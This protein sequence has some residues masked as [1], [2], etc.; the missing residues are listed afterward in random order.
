MI[1]LLLLGIQ[2]EKDT[3]FKGKN[4]VVPIEKMVKQYYKKRGYGPNGGPAAGEIGLPENRLAGEV[5]VKP[6][7]LIFKR[8]Y[9]SV[10]M[11]VLGWFIPMACRK[12][13]VRDEIR[14]FPEDF[15]C[16]LGIWPRG[17]S[18][19]FRK[20][21]DRL[22]KISNSSREVDLGVY[23]KSVEAAWLMFSFQESTCMSEANNRLMAM[24]ELPH[25]CTF[26]RMMDKVEIL[27][28]PKFI[29]KRAVKKW[30]KVK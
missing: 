16:R 1:F 3:L 14:A 4:T 28:L 23:L 18:V 17:A 6:S 30:E 11:A 24:G 8:I 22:K 27:L 12:E 19:T 13:G 29:A 10:I 7:G 2:K 25:T 5:V 21:G 26:I 15:T 9:C 20:D